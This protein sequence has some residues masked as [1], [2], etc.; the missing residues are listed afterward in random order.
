MHVAFMPSCTKDYLF[1]LKPS[2]SS[3]I[4]VPLSGGLSLSV[5]FLVLLLSG[6][7][8]PTAVASEYVPGALPG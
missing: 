5:C 2:H 8:Q 3:D 7:V 4:A 6:E 1:L